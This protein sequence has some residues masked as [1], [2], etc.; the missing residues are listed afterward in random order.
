MALPVYLALTG[1][2]FRLLPRKPAHLAWMGVSF[3]EN[4]TLGGFPE[5]F[6]L[7]GILTVNDASP[8]PEK[9]P[10]EAIEIL[11]QWVEQ[12]RPSAVLMDMQRSGAAPEVMKALSKGLPC[13]VAVSAPYADILPGP[14]LLPPIPL[15]RDPENFLAPWAGREI[16]LEISPLGQV[17]RLT[18][19]GRDIRF[20]PVSPVQKEFPGPCS[21]YTIRK[22]PDSIEFRF[23]RTKEDT[24]ALFAT[25]EKHGVTK[26]FG[27]YLEYR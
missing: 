12:F 11:Q 7:G 27:L 6:P 10:P 3:T 21:R 20:A 26:L 1:A 8:L 2:E 4:G 19:T 5:V 24:A 13:P 14:V 25:A 23:W 16:W 17:V 15:Y 18:K 22:G 9:C